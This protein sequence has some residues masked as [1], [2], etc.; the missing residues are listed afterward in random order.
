MTT[1]ILLCAGKRQEGVA[2]MEELLQALTSIDAVLQASARPGFC[3][4]PHFH[5]PL[6]DLAMSKPALC[7]C[8]DIVGLGLRVSASLLSQLALR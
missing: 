2:D 8:N 1:R 5:I 6:E 4:L 3:H 7:V